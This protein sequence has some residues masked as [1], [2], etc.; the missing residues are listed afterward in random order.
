[1]LFS[2]DDIV[3]DRLLHYLYTGCPGNGRSLFNPGGLGKTTQ[4]TGQQLY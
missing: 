1:M 3:T 2:C 4:D